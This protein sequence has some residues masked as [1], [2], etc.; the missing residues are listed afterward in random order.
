MK[1]VGYVVWIL[2]HKVWVW[3]KS[4]LPLLKYRR[5][6][7]EL[8]FTGTLCRIQSIWMMPALKWLWWPWYGVVAISEISWLIF[9]TPMDFS[10]GVMEKLY[11]SWVWGCILFGSAAWLVK[12]AKRWES[13]LIWNLTDKLRCVELRPMAVAL[14]SNKVVYVH[15]LRK[16]LCKQYVSNIV[17]NVLKLH[18]LSG[19]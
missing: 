5:F 18:F 10:L 6:S 13:F 2:T 8:F 1:F 11:S 9:L 16:M 7:M 4:V 12:K 15:V 19:W 14:C 3:L 17:C